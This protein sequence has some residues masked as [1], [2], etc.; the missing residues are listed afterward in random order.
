MKDQI[1]DLL[2]GADP[3]DALQNLFSVS[4]EVAVASGIGSFTLTQ[5]FSAIA[6]ARF[7]VAAAAEEAEEDEA[8]E[9]EDEEAAE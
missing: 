3:V 5:M 2:E 1:V 4:Y 9:A 7:D 8:E 6:D